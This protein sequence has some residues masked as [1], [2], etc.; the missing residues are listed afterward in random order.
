[1]IRPLPARTT[2]GVLALAIALLAALSLSLRNAEAAASAHPER[3][4]RPRAEE[5]SLPSR[6]TLQR[7]VDEV[8]WRHTVWP[9]AGGEAKPSFAAVTS[10]DA[11]RLKVEEMLRKSDALGRLWRQEI[12][13]Q[14]LQAEI[15]RMVR[16]SRNPEMLREIFDSLNNDPQLI[17]E[18]LARPVLVERLI[19]NFYANDKRLQADS[20]GQ[21]FDEW[22][23]R[24]KGDFSARPAA[25]EGV[26]RLPAVEAAAAASPAN[27]WR[28]MSALPAAT[29]T[30]VWTGSEMIVW[31]GKDSG[32]RYNPAT[33]TWQPTS[34]INAPS[35]RSRHTAV[36]TGTE[37]IIWGGCNLSGSFCGEATGGRYDPLTDTWTPTSNTDA[38]RARREHTAVWTGSEMIIWG[39]CHPGYNSTCNKIGNGGGGVYNPASDTW[40]SIDSPAAPEGRTK[41]TAV[42]TGSEMIVWG[43]VATN[44]T[45]TGGRFNPST[46]AWQPTSLVNAPAPRWEHTAVWTGSLMVVWGGYDGNSQVSFNT[47]G[48]YNPVNDSWEATSLAG[49]PAPRIGHTAVWTGSEMI[50]W[51]GD[52]RFSLGL[53]NTGGRYRPDTDTWTP[54]NQT[55][56][57]SART[58]HLAVWTGSLMIVWS[59]AD[60]QKSGG[61][62]NPG[63]DSWTP[64][65]T[66]DSAPTVY[67]G[68]WTGT[69]MIVWGT[70]PTC[71]SF[72]PSASGRYDPA[73][74]EWRPISQVGEPRIPNRDRPVTAVWTGT[75]MIVWGMGENVYGAPGEGGRYNPSTDSWTPVTK[76]GAPDN[77]SFHTAVWTGSEMIVWGGQN[78]QG[79]ILNTGGRY[80]PTTNTWQPLNTAGAPDARYLHTAV[81]TGSEMIVW[82]GVA[83]GAG[84]LNTGGRYNPSTNTWQ[85]TT[86]GGAPVPRFYHTAIWT[87]SEMIVWGGRDGDYTNNTLIYET[88]GRYNPAANSWQQTSPSGA[89][90]A[91]FRHTAVWTGTEMIVWGGLAKTGVA[92]RDVSTGARYDAAGDTWT[93]T[94]LLRAPSARSAHVALWTGSGMII[95]G[96]DASSYTGTATHGAIYTPGTTT[97]TPTPTPTPNVAPTAKAGGPYAVQVGQAVQFDGSASSDSDGTIS[98]YAWDFGDGSNATGATAVH[99]YA[100]AGTHTVTLTV[101]DDKG[102]TATATAAATVSAAPAAAGLQYYPLAHPVRL[103]DTRPGTTACYTPGAPLTANVAR[104]QAAVGTCDGLSIPPT[105]RAVV[106]NTTVVSPAAA[107]YVT[108]YPSDAALPTA[109]N[110]NYVAGQV[111]PN[112]FTVTLSAAGSFN[113]Y[114]PTQTHLIID[115]AGYYA[116]PGQGGLYYHP[117]PRPVRLLDTRP[118]MTACDAPGAQLQAGGAR[119]EAART[120]CNGVVLP[121]DAQAIVGNAT[122]VNN[123]PGSTDG[124]IILY[125]SGAAQPVVSN[126]NYVAEQVVPNA[127]TVGLGTDGTFNVF[128]ASTTHFIMDITGYYSAS[129]APDSNGV[130]GLL[131]YPLSAPARLL[132]TRAGTTACYTPAA[133]LAANSV[134]TQAARGACAGSTVPAAALAI[135]GNAT[136]VTPSA[137]GYV[138]LYP[139]GAAQP[140]V[141]NLNYLAGQIIPNAFNVTVGGDGAFNIYTPSQTHFIIDLSGYFAP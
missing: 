67:H 118:G 39:G 27:T 25:V 125:P 94:P 2:A 140:V 126:L 46:N 79:P 63:T 14:M 40:R 50:V 128:A 7:A 61:R 98:S 10:P 70:H 136:V 119:T 104:T 139:S 19:R 17:A 132:D 87:G 34:T 74:D 15:N 42:W 55:N 77:R 120:T 117:L 65:S 111:V 91:R 58:N 68:V 8:Y 51:G 72:C 66:R 33:D 1:M 110:L 108:L 124:H 97:T 130:S 138:I 86:T 82:G 54:T 129:A 32:S 121:N 106:G 31:G 28:P 133:P 52:L 114:T 76:T 89:P 5:I 29:G 113:I 88:G 57:P 20:P 85:P 41:H 109:S 134:R 81:W 141:S 9:A 36:W 100:A 64:T 83:S 103:L 22:W 90:L 135:L 59:T 115:V 78:N 24:V 18:A 123:S 62:Y 35:S 56:A 93:P 21:G 75:E 127:F 49:A 13:G 95:W 45:N 23:L 38:P 60:Y 92:Q 11:T 69:E 96:G 137:D 99:T 53:T 48:R 80:N 116:P 26:Y 84:G 71:L 43:G 73:L 3:L 12:D 122:V 4:P 44:V 30:A 107:G 102:S 6:V 105:A 101:T 47:G 16:G 131:F 37:M 112:A